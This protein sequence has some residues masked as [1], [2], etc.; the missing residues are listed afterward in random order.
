MVYLTTLYHIQ[1]L[2]IGLVNNERERMGKE[3]AVTQFQISWNVPGVA[4]KKP[5]DTCHDSSFQSL[6]SKTG[7]LQHT[8]GMPTIQRR[9]HQG[10][11][12][13][14]A[15]K[16]CPLTSSQPHGYEM[17]PITIWQCRAA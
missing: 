16:A 17:R 8:A 2:T 5:R 12:Q 4:G 1:R 6:D 3:A 11:A 14:R 7:L 9:P 13:H 10:Q 15:S